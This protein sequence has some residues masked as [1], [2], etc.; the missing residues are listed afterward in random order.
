V[1]GS[2]LSIA[3]T[4]QT[5]SLQSFAILISGKFTRHWCKPLLM[6]LFCCLLMTL[7]KVPVFEDLLKKINK[8]EIF[9]KLIF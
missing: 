3:A 9:F 5:N 4:E 6:K 7:G 2:W 8:I 1:S